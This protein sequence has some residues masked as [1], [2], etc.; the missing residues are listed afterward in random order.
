[1]IL[2]EAV[3]SSL[4]YNKPDSTAKITH[5][6]TYSLLAIDRSTV[7]QVCRVF[8][9]AKQYRPRYHVSEGTNFRHF[10]PNMHFMR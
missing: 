8:E 6:G 10:N 3:T 2:D 9:H 5:W 4:I 1:M 7:D